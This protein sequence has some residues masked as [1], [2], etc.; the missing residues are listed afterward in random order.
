MWC[1]HGVST[2]GLRKVDT[3]RLSQTLF[4]ALPFTESS[5]SRVGPCRIRQDDHCTMKCNLLVSRFPLAESKFFGHPR[6]ISQLLIYWQ[7]V[8]HGTCFRF[9]CGVPVIQRQIHM[10]TPCARLFQHNSLSQNVAP[11]VYLCSLSSPIFN[12]GHLKADQWVDLGHHGIHM[13]QNERI[14]LSFL[15]ISTCRMEFWWIL[16]WT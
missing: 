13:P 14:T 2:D 7:L 9:S 12:L 8:M 15:N 5:R 10:S 4:L 3:F 11:S 16:P 6:L 1:C